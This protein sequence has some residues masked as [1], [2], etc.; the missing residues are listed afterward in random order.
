MLILKD[1]TPHEAYS[2]SVYS[3]VPNSKFKE[4]LMIRDLG[5]ID[6]ILVVSLPSP[7]SLPQILREFLV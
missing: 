6:S 1:E 3:V 2:G 4:S 7:T 5:M